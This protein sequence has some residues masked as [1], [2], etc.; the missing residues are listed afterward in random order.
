[1]QSLVECSLFVMLCCA[2][3]HTFIYWHTLVQM[4]ANTPSSM[5]SHPHPRPRHLP[6]PRRNLLPLGLPPPPQNILP[7]LG[8]QPPVR[9]RPPDDHLEVKYPSP[10]HPHRRHDRLASSTDR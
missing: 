8:L 4:N 10:T 3:F 9:L 5:A 7:L 1:M 6:R 2:Y